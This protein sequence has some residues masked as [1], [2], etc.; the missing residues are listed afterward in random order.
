VAVL[1]RVLFLYVLAGVMCM[2]YAMLWSGKDGAGRVAA[3][4]FKRPQHSAA[5][6]LRAAVRLLLL[7]LW[8]ASRRSMRWL[9]LGR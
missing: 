7:Q 9:L 3:W 1:E 6:K 8:H 2:G 4:F 5:H